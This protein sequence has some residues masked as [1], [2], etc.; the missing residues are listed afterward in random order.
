MIVRN[1]YH[2]LTKALNIKQIIAITGLR[3]VGKTTTIKYLLDKI[4][5][6]NKIY[7][8]LE[9]IEYRNIFLGEN[10][11]EIIKSLEIEGIDFSQKAYIALD[12]IQLV[13]N[14]TSVIKFIYDTYD[15]KFLI[16]G[17]SSFYMKNT[18]SESLAGRKRIYE[19]WP[20]SF[21][22]LLRFKNINVNL[23]EFDLS[24]TNPHL[25]NKLN[26]YYDEYVNYGGFPEVV[27]AKNND[28][29]IALLK[30]IYNSYINLDIKFL[31]DF[32]KANEIYK[33]LKLFS[34]RVGS[35]IDYSKISGISGINRHK[36]KEYLLFLESTFFIKLVPA[37]VSNPDREIALQ[38]KLYFSDSGLLN[39]L[40]KINSGALFENTVANQLSEK[41]EIRYYAKRTGQEIDFILDGSTAFEVKETASAHDLKILKNRAENIGLK[42]YA[43]IGKNAPDSGFHNFIWGGAIY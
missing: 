16:T 42:K 40:G 41:G 4:K 19:L 32:K 35:K 10:Y 38:N 36:V 11:G 22:E 2:E 3:R 12:E 31:A 24:S 26:V 13:P 28:D 23:P 39:I 6:K 15:V 37:F 1:K 25:I 14:I 20:L 30:D 21:D 8:D 18:F 34:A 29:K 5:N 9:R 7:L 17:S 33:L 43:L 27:L